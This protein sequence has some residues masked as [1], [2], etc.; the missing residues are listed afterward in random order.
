MGDIIRKFNVA[1]IGGNPLWSSQAE[2][3]FT[4]QLGESADQVQTFSAV[5]CDGTTNT[6]LSSP[7]SV[8]EAFRACCATKVPL[9]LDIT[10]WGNLQTLLSNVNLTE[11]L[12]QR[13]NYRPQCSARLMGLLS[14]ESGKLLGLIESIRQALAWSDANLTDVLGDLKQRVVAQQQ[15]LAAISDSECDDLQERYSNGEEL[16][17][18][19]A[20]DALEAE[21]DVL[22]G[23]KFPTTTTKSLSGVRSVTLAGTQTILF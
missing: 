19:K 9:Y 20:S 3:A 10:P 4:K 18:L 22:V 16:A 6:S 17:L 15:K 5:T 1:S 7:S 2:M 8:L 23:E 12:A 21:Y 11:E 13:F 14:R